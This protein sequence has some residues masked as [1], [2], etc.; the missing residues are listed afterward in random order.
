MNTFFSDLPGQ[1]STYA[2]FAA[3]MLKRGREDFVLAHLKDGQQLCAFLE[4]NEKELEALWW[5]SDTAL[6]MGRWKAQAFLESGSDF[7]NWVIWQI[8]NTDLF[9]KWADYIEM[10]YAN[11][12]LRELP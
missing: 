5:R 11:G 6:E 7:I 3:N 8:E 4:D 10:L 1:E 2:E 12:E 9:A